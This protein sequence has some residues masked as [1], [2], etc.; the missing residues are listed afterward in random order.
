MSVFSFPLSGKGHATAIT[1]ARAYGK[2]ATM[3]TGSTGIR[4]ARYHADR[5]GPGPSVLVNYN[6]PSPLLLIHS[7]WGGGVWDARTA[8][9]L[10]V[11]THLQER[12]CT[13]ARPHPKHALWITMHGHAHLGVSIS[14]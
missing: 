11:L 1:G 10:Q 9:G 2:L 12:P 14:Y 5:H 4:E 3:L 7:P 13:R 8:H 6:T